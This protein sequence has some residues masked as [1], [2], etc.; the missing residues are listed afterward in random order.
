MHQR[1]TSTAL[2]VLVA[3]MAWGCGDGSTETN[4]SPPEH[5]STADTGSAT[6]PSTSG[7]SDAGSD[8]TGVVVD[9]GE[10]D[11]P[12]T[13]P[14]ELFAEVDVR[15]EPCALMEGGDGR[16][17]GCATASM[18]LFWEAHDGQTLGIRAKRL[19]PS[20]EVTAQLWLVHGGPGA[21]GVVGL[22]GLMS[23]LHGLMPGL[24]VYTLDHRG[25]G[26]SEFLECPEQQH[27]DSDLGFAISDAE[28]M[29]CLTAIQAIWGDGLDTLGSTSS[30]IDLAAYI[31][32]SRRPETPVFVWGGSYGAYLALRF[33]KLFPDAVDGVILEGIVKPDATFIN[34]DETSD[35]AGRRLLDDCAADPACAERLGD[36]P[37]A[38]LSEA[39]RRHEAGECA[40][41]D[42]EPQ[43]F[44][45]LLVY[46]MYSWTTSGAVPALI[47][48]YHRCAPEDGEA[49]AHVWELLFGEEGA[50]VADTTD[51]SYSILLQLHVINSEMWAHPEYDLADVPAALASFWEGC[52]FCRRNIQ[53]YVDT[54]DLWPRYDDSAH[55]DSYP[56]TDVPTLMLHGRLDPTASAPEAEEVGARLSGANQTL[57]LF[58]QAAHNV[59]N[60]TPYQPLRPHCGMK[61]WLDFMADPTAELDT[62]CVEEVTPI[63]FE[64]SP[65]LAQAL[66]GTSS[67][68][69]PEGDSKSAPGAPDAGVSEALRLLRERVR[70]DRRLR[71]LRSIAP[72]R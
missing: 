65:Q 38:T 70:A 25:T 16:E 4:N 61:L 56:V 49:L 40:H 63:N 29:D 19:R 11:A 64:G 3:I 46:M 39:L 55:G 6:S 58:P 30:A 2:L 48:R 15:W 24:E 52:L 43:G 33:M 50:L 22:P 72:G 36:D 26:Y 10:P 44:Q 1:K 28:F 20:G 41:V 67:F 18:P 51:L 68:F 31:E 71:R 32:A 27:P 9:A 23:S 53:T 45:Q 7:M 47:Y 57:V 34:H 12:P 69:E 14:T 17:A 54:Y 60:G 37:A 62:S 5:N 66:F 59:S 35:R 8:D 21:S 13:E 42:I